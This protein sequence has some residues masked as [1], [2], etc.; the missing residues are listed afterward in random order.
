M[1]RG[2][3]GAAVDFVRSEKRD[4][5]IGNRKSLRMPMCI[6]TSEKYS[7]TAH[8][9]S[10]VY[11]FDPQAVP[12]QAILILTRRFNIVYIDTKYI[13]DIIDV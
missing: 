5:K 2:W 1:K 8:H 3:F 13:N 6:S 9:Q 12:E 7:D 4:N 11:F 10:V